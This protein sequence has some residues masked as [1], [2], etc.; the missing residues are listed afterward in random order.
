MAGYTPQLRGL[1]TAEGDFHAEFTTTNA[2]SREDVRKLAA[3]HPSSRQV[4]NFVGAFSADRQAMW[5]TWKRTLPIH[6]RPIV[7]SVKDSHHGPGLTESGT[8]EYRTFLSLVQA[9]CS[10]TRRRLDDL[11]AEMPGDTTV[12][13]C[14]EVMSKRLDALEAALKRHQGTDA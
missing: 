6:L 1:G 2:R 5:V 12:S 3:A 14:R 7:L 13:D 4:A 8:A 11:V 10:R 9:V